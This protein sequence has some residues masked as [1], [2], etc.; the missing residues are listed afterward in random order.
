MYFVAANPKLEIVATNP[1]G[2]LSM[3]TPAISE[4]T[5]F[6]RTSSQ[7]IAV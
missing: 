4:G 5:L 2:D 7:V 3:A 1:L 6:F